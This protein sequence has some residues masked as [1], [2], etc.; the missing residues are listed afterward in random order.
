MGL[1]LGLGAADKCPKLGSLELLALRVQ[2]F[3]FLRRLKKLAKQVKIVQL[4]GIGSGVR[5]RT[6]R[7]LI[8]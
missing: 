6:L 4:R 3:G 7:N 8:P 1:G 2:D 5:G